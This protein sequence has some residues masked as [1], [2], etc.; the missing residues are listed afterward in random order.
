MNLNI[1]FSQSL[2]QAVFIS[3]MLDLLQLCH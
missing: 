1:V 2:L 3:N